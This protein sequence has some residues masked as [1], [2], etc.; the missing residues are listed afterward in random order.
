MN[1]FLQFVV[2]VY[3]CLFIC[4][5]PVLSVLSDLRRK[6]AADLP[7]KLCTRPEA[8]ALYKKVSEEHM[9]WCTCRC[10]CT[11]VTVYVYDGVQM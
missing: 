9:I 7:F 5:F 4:C 8:D 11:D 10:E 1:F 2:V 3:N 6:R